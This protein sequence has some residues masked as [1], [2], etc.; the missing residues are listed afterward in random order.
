MRRSG[1]RSPSAPPPQARHTVATMCLLPK[2]LPDEFGATRRP[3]RPPGRQT[4]PSRSV[5]DDPAGIALRIRIEP[6][7][8]DVAIEHFVPMA[9][10]GKTEAI[11]VIV[12]RALV[13][14]RDDHDI[15]ADARQPAMNG[16]DAVFVVDVKHV[17][18]F[19]AQG[20]MFSSKPHE[21]AREAM[22]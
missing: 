16:D 2:A 12:E 17:Q 18:A 11:T 10:A 13:Q 6:L 7:V 3:T 1:V 15:A 5:G 9:A 20:R 8:I 4:V 14:A 21:V 19:A 22:L